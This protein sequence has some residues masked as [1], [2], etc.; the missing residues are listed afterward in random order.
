ME[1]VHE[2][3]AFLENKPGRLAKICSALAQEKIDIR[4]LSV[5]ETEGPSVLRLITSELSSTKSV[6]TSLGTEFRVSEVLA[7]QLENRTGAL[8][9]VLEKLAE[10]HINVE[11]AYASTASAPGKALGIFHTSNPKRASQIL[12]DAASAAPG[13]PRSTGRRPLHSR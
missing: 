1:F 12:T 2:V 11:Y 3:T 10:E 7:V 6:L 5:M 4:A 9:K 13:S 8:A